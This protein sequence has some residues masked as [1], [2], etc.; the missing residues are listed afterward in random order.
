MNT[1]TGKNDIVDIA[2]LM[3]ESGVKF[4][5]SGARGLVSAMTDRVCY[6]YTAAFIQHL[7]SCGEVGHPGSRIAIA[8]DYRSSTGRIMCAIAR[9]VIDRGYRVINCG[10]IPSPAVALYGIQENIPSI[11]VTGSHI[12][13][14]RNGIKYNT[15]TG[16]ILKKDE[17]GIRSQSITL[18]RGLF[19]DDG[20]LLEP[21]LPPKDEGAYN[22]YIR[23]YLDFFP[24]R[25]LEGLHIG[26]YEHSSV[27]RE[28]VNDILTSL[29]ARVTKLG[30][31]ETFLPVDTEAIRDD[32]V[33]LAQEWAGTYPLHSIV[34]TDGDGDRP[35]ISDE[36]GKWL[37]GDMAGILCAGFLG[38]EVVV[39]PVSSNTAV[40]K[41][42]LFREI[43]R[44]RIGS[45]YVIAGMNAAVT[46]GHGRVVGYEANGGF[47]TADEIVM[48]GQTLAP[49]P[50]RDTLIVLVSI[51][52]LSKQRGLPISGLVDGLPRRFTASNRLKEFPT[53]LSR[54]KL[55]ELYSGDPETDRRQIEEYFGEHFGLVAKL[56]N[57]DG[58]RITFADDE[59]V[60]LR[61]SGNAPEFRCYNEAD[62]E[63]RAMGMNRI[64]LKIMATWRDETY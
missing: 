40:E 5:T 42:A 45:P 33:R 37:R 54:R 25:C 9:A 15:P 14:D 46:D 56:D 38:A 51:L 20:G 53:S 52:L 48:D 31:S 63:Q 39:T 59:I 24:P 50:T 18:P 3:E 43:R 26:V 55:E 35:L 27:A 17:A 1:A 64:C 28:A 41:T 60:H 58:L 8:G 21:G 23:R 10:T 11:M 30:Y 62:S 36:N 44:T 19:G 4:G 32:D 7:E 61:P 12:P 49:L 2:I 47:L 34:S 6:A 22:V 29:G 16:E 57:T 13:D